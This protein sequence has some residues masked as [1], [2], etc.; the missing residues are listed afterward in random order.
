[1]SAFNDGL[2]NITNKTLPRLILVKGMDSY[3]RMIKLQE[4]ILLLDRT[5]AELNVTNKNIRSDSEALKRDLYLLDTQVVT[6]ESK[7]K[8]KQS[9]LDFDLWSESYQKA[10]VQAEAGKIDEAAKI[11]DS[12]PSKALLDIQV[13]IDDIG[14][15]TAARM[16]RD[17]KASGVEFTNSKIYIIMVSLGSI[18]LGLVLAFLVLSRLNRSIDRIITSLND[19]SQQVSSASHQIASSS[20]ELSQGATEQASS[21]EQTSA[22]VEEM[23]SMV[24]RNAE[25]AKTSATSCQSSA[26][27]ALKGKRV[28]DEMKKAMDEIDSSNNQIMLQTNRNDVEFAEIVRVIGMIGEKTKVINDIVFQTKLLSFNASVEAARAGEHGKGFAVVAEEVGTLAQMSGN[29]AKEITSLLDKS[30]LQVQGIVQDSKITMEKLI[31]ETKARVVAGSRVAQSC[32]EVLD[33]IV[34]NVRAA[35]QMSQSISAAS[36]EQANGVTEITKAVGQLDQMTQQN[37]AVSEQAASAAEELSAQ[38]ES[39]LGVVLSLTQT[40]KGGDVSKARL[41]RVV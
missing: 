15:R 41:R 10:F 37:A 18:I 19:N 24:Q 17:T 36:D 2:I 5:A 25:S 27:S 6:E 31:G 20:Q 1:M 35:A 4:K 39:M 13:V 29:A 16:D 38:A 8:L 40:I 3:I 23:N 12:A 22:S 11:L 21:L 28:V 34:V 26:E 30:V 7:I 32:G 9:K 33:E 14:Q